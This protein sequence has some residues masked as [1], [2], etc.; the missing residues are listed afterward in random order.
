MPS[1]V[2]PGVRVEA[3]FDVLPPLPATSGIV[4]AVGIVDRPPEAPQLIAVTKIGELREILGPGTEATMPEA[5]HALA[6]GAAELV[7]SAV[8]GGTAASA[9]LLNASAQPAVKLRCRSRGAWGTDLKAEVKAI[10]DG[11]NR[12]IR[13]TI[14][15]L[16]GG[17]VVETFS[18]L[19]VAPGRP[20]DLFDTIN[21]G[22]RYVV[23]LDPGFDGIAPQP[24]TFTFNEAGDA[25]AVREQGGTRELFSLFPADGVSPVGLSVQL[26]VAASGRVT[27]KISQNGPQE[28]LTGLTT[29]PD[30]ADYLPY[31]L[32]Q[33]S[34]FVRVRPAS[35]LPA[36]A[37]L[38]STTT[39]PVDFAGG[40]SPS[41]ND[42]RKAIELLADD[43]RIDLVIASI[44]PKRPDGEVRQI[45]E[46]LL[47]H[48][49]AAA[50]AGAPRIA[51]GSITANEAKSINAI[52]EHAALVRNRRFALVAPP[53]AE[54]AV[55]GTIG[56]MNPQDSPTF[57]NVPLHG[58]E[59]AKFRASELDRLL[60]PAFN[61]LVVQDRPGRGVVVLRGLDATGDQISVTRVADA[62]IRETKAISEN[63]IGRLNTEDARVALKQQIV[64]TFT[65]MERD[66]ALVPSTDG[67]DPAFVVDVYSTQLDFAQGIV[68]IDIAVRP[69]RAI[70][71]IYA[72]IRVKN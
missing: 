60:G 33:R 37:Q 5:V 12:V 7:V 23:A 29:D 24:G 16:L 30:D 22:S 27:V 44:E 68:R 10:T 54:G 49:V 26:E 48:A 61:L 20:D 35:S 58:F 64:A 41:V 34:R 2:V 67:K 28:Q 51:F 56:R 13:S 63:F 40:D 43:P 31:A 53:R 1:L 47:A 71:Y 69:V 55:A 17:K 3:R 19:R 32:M 15:L 25:I 38:P 9:S 21:Q 66:G 46:A 72:T 18:D 39:T 42:Y 62:A 57:K 45:H 11:Q 36:E 4:G 59:P 50:D 14:R 8:T 70:D 52:R 6:N 65:R